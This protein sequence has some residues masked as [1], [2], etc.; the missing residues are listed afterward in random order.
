MKS[1]SFTDAT[2]HDL[3]R[4]M[5]MEA[6]GFAAGI[7]E[8]RDVYAARISAF[9]EGSLLAHSSADCIGC[10]FGEIW[11]AAPLP[12]AAHFALDHDILDRHDPT[13][14]SELYIASMT[15]DPAF[16]GRGFGKSLF[17]GGIAHV[18]AAFPQLRSALLLVNEN[19]NA[20]HGIYAAAGFREVVRF[21]DFFN[22][23]GSTREDGIV[24]RRDIQN[25]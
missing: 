16:R 4:I 18:A 8:Q 17:L 20:A 1:L 6:R 22:P 14:G 10:F 12:V 9:P 7:R 19:W 21:G 3:D 24:M 13:R 15:I 2:L 11:Q 5:D 23:H 25:D